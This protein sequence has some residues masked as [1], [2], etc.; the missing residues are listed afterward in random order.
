MIGTNPTY[1]AIDQAIVEYRKVVTPYTNRV[2]DF[3]S[4]TEKACYFIVRQAR[5]N[6]IAIGDWVITVAKKCVGYKDSSKLNC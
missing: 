1:A 6:P 4:A 5:N 3:I 2:R